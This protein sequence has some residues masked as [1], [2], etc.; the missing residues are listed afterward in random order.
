MIPELSV[1]LLTND[2]YFLDANVYSNIYKL[3]KLEEG[4][5]AVDIGAHAGYSVVNSVLRGAGK[6]YAVEPYIHNFELLLKNISKVR[7][8]V[9]PHNLAILF[10]KNTVS[11]KAPV[12][13]SEKYYDFADLEVSNEKRDVCPCVSLDEFLGQYVHEEKVSLLKINTGG[14]YDKDILLNSKEISRVESI[15]GFSKK[16]SSEKNAR[17]SEHLL[18]LGFKDQ[19]TVPFPDD[20]GEIFFAS[21]SS[22]ST[23]F[24]I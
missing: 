10:D 7:D 12:F 16:Q 17:F 13:L 19:L 11:F 14:D 1:R 24:T 9:S 20:E 2:Q 6:V 3:S 5:V 23:H 21:K 15:C 22:L 8:S 4:A 18:S